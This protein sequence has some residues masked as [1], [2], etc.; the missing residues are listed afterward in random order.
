MGGVSASRR[1]QIFPDGVVVHGGRQRHEDVPDGVGE[2]DDA[3][4]PEEE[5][6]GDVDEAAARQLLE[7]LGVALRETP[8]LLKPRPPGGG[9]THDNRGG[10]G[11][12]RGRRG[13][14]VGPKEAGR[15]S[16][17]Q[18]SSRPRAP[19]GT[20][21]ARRKRHQSKRRTHQRTRTLTRASV[22]DEAEQGQI[23]WF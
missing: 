2:G 21:A 13:G 5:D 4:A 10:A 20:A 23:V 16:W 7:A 6:A 11:P 22:M 17:S 15:S 3:V 12:G 19:E 14:R 18:V 8:P 9:R 1:V